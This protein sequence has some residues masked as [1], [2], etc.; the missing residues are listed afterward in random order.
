MAQRADLHALLRNAAETYA[1]AGVPIL[2]LYEVRDGRCAC[3]RSGCD[4]PGKHPRTPNG[5][6]SASADPA[7][8]ARWWRWWPTANVGAATG[9]RFDVWDI[10]LPD[11]GP[12][13]GKFLGG[14]AGI[15]PA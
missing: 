5:V 8:V 10:D 7:V 9:H 1:L 3:G 11:A 2:P 4:R 15:W 14:T 13:L 6:H 12:L